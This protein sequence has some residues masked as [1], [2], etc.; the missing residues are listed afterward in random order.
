MEIAPLFEIILFL[1][2]N[3]V[4]PD[5]EAGQLLGDLIDRTLERIRMKMHSIAKDAALRVIPSFDE[6]KDLARRQDFITTR[7]EPPQVGSCHQRRA[8]IGSD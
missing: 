8:R 2:A 3:V 1:V 5:K 6:L 7:S 4:S